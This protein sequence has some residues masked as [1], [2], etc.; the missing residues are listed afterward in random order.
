METI[1]SIDEQTLI[2]K[3]QK[4]DIKAYESLVFKYDKRVMALIRHSVLNDEDA[5]ELYQDIF[6]KVYRSIGKYGKNSNFYTWLY[7]ITINTCLNYHQ[8]KSTR[9]DKITETINTDSYISK[10]TKQNPESVMMNNELQETIQEGLNNL[11]P[12]EKMVFILKHYEGLKIREIADLLKETDG[13]VKNC[14]FRGI[15]KLKIH[16]TP[17]MK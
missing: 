3:A 14:L 9:L 2:Q 6:L 8:K 10:Q 17:L 13:S 1:N 15:K 16:L 11:S 7:R 12:K 4:G 5:K